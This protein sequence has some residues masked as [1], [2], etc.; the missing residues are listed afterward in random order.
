MKSLTF[1]FLFFISFSAFA[2]D[3]HGIKSGM[4]K[5]EVKKLTKCK[6]FETCLWQETERFFKLGEDNHPPSLWDMQFSYTSDNR[7]W[8]IL[9][10]FEEDSGTRGAAQLRALKE[11]YPDAEFLEG[12]IGSR[13]SSLIVLLIDSDIFNKDVEKIYQETIDKY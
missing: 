11:L 4:S 10:R 2:F 9:L 5:T 6:E 13:A 3:Y 7:L 12:R 8:R 1:L